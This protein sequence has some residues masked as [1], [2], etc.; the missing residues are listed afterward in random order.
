MDMADASALAD[1][2]FHWDEVYVIGFDADTGVWHARYKNTRPLKA[3][4]ASD[5]RQMI[6]TDYAARTS[7][8][9]SAT[10]AGLTERM[11]T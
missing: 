4:S 10:Y 3:G 8:S 6:R 1:L 11:S 9:I 2:R 5:L 7:R